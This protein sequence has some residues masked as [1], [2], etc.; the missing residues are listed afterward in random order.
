[1]SSSAPPRILEHLQPYQ[2]AV[3]LKHP[4]DHKS[5]ARLTPLYLLQ[6]SM[7][8]PPVRPPASN[9]CHAKSFSSFF[10]TIFPP[11]PAVCCGKQIIP[12]T[13]CVC[14]SVAVTRRPMD[15]CWLA[16]RTGHNTPVQPAD[17]HLRQFVYCESQIA[18]L[19]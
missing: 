5:T 17:D 18:V 15:R 9:Q 11:F 12:W 2:N 3:T 1:M 6:Q 16:S 4:T 14:L 8:A 19:N 10:Y 7:S 13:R